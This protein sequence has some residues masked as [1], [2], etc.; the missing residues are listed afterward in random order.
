[1]ITEAAIRKEIRAVEAGR[2]TAATLTDP[3]PRGAGRLALV[4]RP[5]RAEWYAQ[6]WA[7]GRRTLQKLGAWPALSIAEARARHGSVGRTLGERATLQDLVDGYLATLSGRTGHSEAR[8]ILALVLQHLPG[9]RLARGIEPAD[10]VPALRTIY[11]ARGASTADRA[12]AW[13]SAAFGW[14]VPAANDY[15]TE[16]ATSYGV[17]RNPVQDIAKDGTASKPGTH[18]LQP[19]E[20]V[21]LLEWL[22]AGPANRTRTAAML[23]AL[24][25]Q[26]GP[27][28]R[29]IRADQWDSAD[30]VLSWLPGDMKVPKPHRIPVPAT[31]AAMLDALQP[32]GRGMLLVVGRST[33]QELLAAAPVRVTARDLR[34]TWKTLAAAAGLTKAE[35]DEYQAHGLAGDIAEIHYNKWEGLPEKRAALAKWESWLEKQ[36][37]QHGAN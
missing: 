31:V 20:L 16:A 30:R 17:R 23:L 18:W 32:D 28:L 1:M 24:T 37:R 14:A 4:V 36:A 35:R 26:R 13:L 5:G 25:G 15:R 10:I 2:K 29:R 12:R 3:A 7:A 27:Q 34:R 6:R 21:R 8:R 11:L 9:T 33:V 19:A 22:Q